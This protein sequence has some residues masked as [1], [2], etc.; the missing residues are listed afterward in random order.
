MSTIIRCYQGQTPATTSHSPQADAGRQL[1]SRLQAG[2]SCPRRNPAGKDVRASAARPAATPGLGLAATRS[3]VTSSPAHHARLGWH[4]IKEQ[5][6]RSGPDKGG[7]ITTGHGEGRDATFRRHGLHSVALRLRDQ[8]E[9]E[10]FLIQNLFRGAVMMIRP[11]TSE[12]HIGD[13]NV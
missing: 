2:A 4:E 8:G 12:S 11:A 9:Q 3:N 13:K 6:A 1:E 5:V 7:R 10:F